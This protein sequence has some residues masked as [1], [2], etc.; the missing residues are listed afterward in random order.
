MTLCGW[1]AGLG[2]RV[3]SSFWM[4]CV[5]SASSWQACRLQFVR[6]CTHCHTIAYKASCKT[7]PSTVRVI[8]SEAKQSR[9]KNSVRLLLL[10]CFVAALPAMTCDRVGTAA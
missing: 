7:A 6:G 10:D 5:P 3:D 1:S 8:A 2:G 9:E 4:K